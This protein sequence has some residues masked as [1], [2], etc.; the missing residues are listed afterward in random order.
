MAF[1]SGHLGSVTATGFTGFVETWELD[2]AGPV[3]DVTVL[4]N[5][6]QGNLGGLTDFVVRLK[7]YVDSASPFT[8]TDPGTSVVMSLK[9]NAEAANTDR[10][11]CTGMIESMNWQLAVDAPSRFDA[12]IRANGTLVHKEQGAA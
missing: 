11:E 2:N 8:S 1:Q 10:Y 12:V 6:A 4:G 5:L 9:M 7:G 3:H